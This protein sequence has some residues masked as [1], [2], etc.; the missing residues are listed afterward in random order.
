MREFPAP[1]I[2]TGAY[3]ASELSLLWAGPLDGS[4]RWFRRCWKLR[5][6]NKIKDS[7]LT[8]QANIAPLPT[9][10]LYAERYLA[11]HGAS[12]YSRNNEIHRNLLARHLLAS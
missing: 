1:R 10:Q 11:A 12:I 6:P 8:Q 5:Q 9:G 2:H 7:E 3:E 4:D